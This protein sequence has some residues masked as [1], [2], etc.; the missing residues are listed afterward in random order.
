M[1]LRVPRKLAFIGAVLICLSGIVNALLGARIGALVY[2]VYP[3]GRMGHVGIIAGVA[4]I[5][6]GLAIAL[7]VVPIYRYSLRNRVVQASLLTMVLG[8]LG[9]VTGALYVGTAGVLLCYIAG[10]WGMVVV[11]KSPRGCSDSTG[12]TQVKNS[13][14]RDMRK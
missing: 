5:L 8:H 7:M 1:D 6:I 12:P 11:W 10:I 13:S 2:E 9:A 3:G 4:A 14:G